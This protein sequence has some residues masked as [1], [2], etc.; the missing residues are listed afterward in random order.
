MRRPVPLGL[1]LFLSREVAIGLRPMLRHSNHGALGIFDELDAGSFHRETVFRVRDERNLAHARID[2]QT[3]RVQGNHDAPRDRR[4]FVS[5]RVL[6]KY[7][8]G[9]AKFLPALADQVRIVTFVLADV[10][11]QI[12]VRDQI[13]LCRK[14]PRPGIRFGIVERHL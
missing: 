2:H 10:F 12:S 1:H 3:I 7:F 13:E 5:A 9:N 11:N 6:S 14:R 4:R 8:G